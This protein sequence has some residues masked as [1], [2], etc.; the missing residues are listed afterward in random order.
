MVSRTA[1]LVVVSC[2]A[3]AS[4]ASAYETEALVSL[5]QDQSGHGVQTWELML[6][7]DGTIVEE[8]YNIYVKDPARFETSKEVRRVSQE[9]ARQL[10]S[11]AGELIAGLPEDVETRIVVDPETKAIRIRVGEK[12]LFAGWSLYESTP[13]SDGTRAFQRAWDAIEAILR[14]PDA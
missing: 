3:L 9:Q 4:E 6:R 2:L 8:Q 12:K 13:P 11:K 1:V 5:R 7:K 14:R 10:A